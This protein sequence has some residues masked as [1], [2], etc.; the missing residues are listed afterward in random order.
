MKRRFPAY[1]PIAFVAALALACAL[2]VGLRWNPVAS[3]LVAITAVSFATYGVDKYAARQSLSRVPE[4]V[5][6]GLALAGGT[7]GALAASRVFRHKTQ[8]LSFRWKFW[9]VVALQ[10]IVAAAVFALRR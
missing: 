5:L 9:V 3:W 1:G 10:C 4:A 7:I 8:K 2:A 6:L